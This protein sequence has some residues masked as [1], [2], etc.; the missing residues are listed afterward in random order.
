MRATRAGELSLW[1]GAATALAAREATFAVLLAR[2][3]MTGP[4]EP[5]TGRHGLQ[6]LVTGAFELAPFGTDGDRFLILSTKTKYWPVEYNL[7]AVVWAAI[8]LRERCRVSE[9]ESVEVETYWSAWHET[10]S[11][12]AK[13]DP[14][15]RETADHSMPYA[16][17]RTLTDGRLDLTAFEERAYLDPAL[18]PLIGRVAVHV[19]DDIE[20]AFPAETRLRA[21]ALTTSGQRIR[22]E[23]INPLGD[24]RNPLSGAQLDDKFRRLV[25]PAA[26]VAAADRA[27]AALRAI[28]DCPSVRPALDSLVP[29]ADT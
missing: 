17:A 4:S 1:K 18:R 23:I 22:V 19:A 5:V 27:L 8:E 20:A 26:G 29:P 11:E 16:L 13:W 28:A 9:I 14:R 6:D 10:A 12:R 2:E 3:G 15:T 24:H 25:T 21:T 7:Q